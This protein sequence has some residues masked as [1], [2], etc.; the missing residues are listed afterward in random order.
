MGALAS[1]CQALEAPDPQ[2]LAEKL[3]E[4]EAV[5]QDAVFRVLFRSFCLGAVPELSDPA[6]L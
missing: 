2:S 3:R 1:I 5:K 6:L 4:K